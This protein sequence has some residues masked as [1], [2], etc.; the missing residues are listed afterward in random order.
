MERK[1][2][3]DHES[4]TKNRVDLLVAVSLCTYLM[5]QLERDSAKIAAQNTK[6]SYW[7]IVED[8]ISPTM[9][10]DMIDRKGLFQ[11]PP[12][13]CQFFAILSIFGLVLFRHNF[14]SVQVSYEE[15]KELIRPSEKRHE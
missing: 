15:S 6:D 2:D 1:D 10:I 14:D 8:S 9:T 5:A 7:A 12:V 11:D 4:K 13:A 3:T